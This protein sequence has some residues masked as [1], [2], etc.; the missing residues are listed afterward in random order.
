MIRVRALLLLSAAACMAL[1][2]SDKVTLKYQPKV[3]DTHKYSVAAHMDLGGASADYTATITDTLKKI[4]SDGNYVSSSSTTD[5]QAVTEQGTFPVPDADVST[6][7]KPDGETVKIDSAMAD[8]NAYRFA[9]LNDFYYPDTPVDVGDT[10]TKK[11][12]ADLKTGSLETTATYKVLGR[13]TAVG[14][15]CLKVSVDSKESGPDGAEIT[16]TEWFAIKD[17][18]HVRSELTWK[19]V[20]APG[21]PG[22]VNGKVTVTLVP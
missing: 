4:D 5:A 21:A 3:G 1:A 14:M 19:N 15:D 10:W 20:P 17:G 8:A 22:P 9:A 16:G 2:A 13:E 12:P 6:T 11:L 18:T 7:T